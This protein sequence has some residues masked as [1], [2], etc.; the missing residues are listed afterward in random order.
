MRRS[1]AIIRANKRSITLRHVVKPDSAGTS[2]HY[3]TLKHARAALAKR[4]GPNPT[5]QT[6]DYVINAAGERI[7]FKGATFEELFTPD[8]SLPGDQP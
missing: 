2:L 8:Q 6:G 3:T 1:N 5:K 4:I 7:Y